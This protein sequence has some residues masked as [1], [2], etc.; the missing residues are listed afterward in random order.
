M[1]IDQL[2]ELSQKF[3]W[4]GM[5]K[6]CIRVSELYTTAYYDLAHGVG[7]YPSVKR[8]EFMQGLTV[9][10]HQVRKTIGEDAYEKA[11]AQC[12]ALLAEYLPK[13]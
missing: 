2:R 13:L 10:L 4:R 9:Y 7:L 11:A 12:S 8:R 1:T 5:Q 3:A 6:E